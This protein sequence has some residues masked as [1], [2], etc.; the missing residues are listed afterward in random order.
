[1]KQFFL[2]LLAAWMTLAACQRTTDCVDALAFKANSGEK[3][4]LISTDGHILVPANTFGQQPTTVVGGM[5]SLPDG[6]GNYQLYNI[7]QPQQPVSPRSFACIGHFF[8]GVAPAQESPQSPILLIDKQARTI[9]STEQYP[10]YDIALVHNFREGLALIATREGKYGYM[11]IRG[12]IVIPPI[13]DRAYDF[14]NGKALVGITNLQ[15]KTG[16]LLI[17]P[18]GKTCLAIQ[19]E[20]CV[21]SH[22]FANKRL[23]YK[24]LDSG[25]C[26][27]LDEE[28]VP[29]LCLPEEVKEAY[30][31]EHDMALFQTAT[32]TGII[33]PRGEILI[34]AHYEN[35]FIAGDN[36]IGLKLKEHWTMA[37]KGG[38]LLCDFQ[39]DA[40]GC[41]Y[42]SNL[43]VAQEEGKFLFIT[44][45]GKPADS[46]RYA[47]I[48]ED[49]TARQEFPQ[50]FIRREKEDEKDTEKTTFQKVSDKPSA[51]QPKSA[52]QI[53]VPTQ[54]HIATDSWK[55]ISKQ[56]PFY[57][58]ASKVLSG[59]LE[60]KDAGHR[61]MI[62]NYVEHLRTS[63]TTKDIDFLEQL[64]SE[65]A[66]I[67][68]G[69]VVRTGP[70]AEGSYLSPSQV[71][72]NVKSKRQYLDRLK[73]VFKANKEIQVDFTGFRIMRHPTEPGIYGV[74]LRQGY[75]SDIYSDD[76]YLFLLWDF[77]D[78]TS[79]QI[80]VRTWQPVTTGEHDTLPADEVF[81]ISNFNLK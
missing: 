63:Y 34:P 79:P 80:H 51:T 7:H 29:I 9:A 10:Q 17:A 73:Q 52:P 53:N 11:N 61:R 50:I 46:N 35:A 74:S 25:R 70:Q 59:K 45:K 41:Y 21:I 18:N 64:F 54:S 33:D 8:E 14:C 6:K 20:N 15:G 38:K 77:K 75:R 16:Y 37:E 48:A 60:E 69:T 5:F 43:A 31:F 28:G 49:A 57:T 12:K 47:F 72:Y 36:R 56:N 44:R 68:V 4:G 76:G 65:N 3:W 40:I 58:E 32:G 71:I 26:C 2:P 78:E 30:P 1:M 39:Y 27:Y 24:H 19:Q 66:L 42:G 67:I 23:M 55:E 62:L 81:D 22:R 13:Y